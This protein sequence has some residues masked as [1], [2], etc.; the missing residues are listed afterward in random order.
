MLNTTNN[1]PEY[2]N[3]IW[4]DL[5]LYEYGTRVTSENDTNTIGKE[6]VNRINPGKIH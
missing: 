5:F 3:G 1:V 6:L 2:L 4:N